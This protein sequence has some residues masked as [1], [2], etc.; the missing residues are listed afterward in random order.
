LQV[1]I[2]TVQNNVSDSVITSNTKAYFLASRSQY[3]KKIL[4]INLQFISILKKQVMIPIITPNHPL[5]P[6]IKLLAKQAVKNFYTYKRSKND[7]ERNDKC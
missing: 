5:Y 6:L 4:F 3:L 7:S 1:S 2:T